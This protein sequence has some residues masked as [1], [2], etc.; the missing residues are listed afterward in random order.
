MDNQKPKKEEKSNFNQQLQ[1]LRVLTQ[2]KPNFR[3]RVG[4]L[5]TYHNAAMT[6]AILI[7][8]IVGRTRVFLPDLFMLGIPFSLLAI[9][10]ISW[11]RKVGWSDLGFS[12]PKNWLKIIFVGFGTAVLLQ[13]LALLQIKL[14]GPIPDIRSFEHIKNNP[15]ALLGML[16]ISWTTAG[17]GEEII[18]RGFFMTQIARLLDDQKNT[19][20]AIALFLSSIV[21][22]LIHAY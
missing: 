2:T 5:L 11:F 6:G 9:W 22:G 21:F 13:T 1:N 16:L 18:W 15:W 17:F 4:N 7:V 3:V 10:L 12:R 14:G 20:W 8:F 19:S